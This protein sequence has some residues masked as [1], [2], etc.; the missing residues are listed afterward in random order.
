MSQGLRSCEA[1]T[2]R[3][4]E[5][6]LQ[7]L[8]RH[9]EETLGLGVQIEKSKFEQAGE[10]FAYRALANAADTSEEYAHVAPMDE[11]CAIPS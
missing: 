7:P 6:A 5:T 1:E 4:Q 8:K 2:V 10:L 11:S 3:G 9:S